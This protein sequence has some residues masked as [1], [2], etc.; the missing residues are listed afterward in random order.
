MSSMRYVRLLYAV[1]TTLPSNSA[2]QAACN[3]KKRV[4]YWTLKEKTFLSY[5]E[6]STLLT[7]FRHNI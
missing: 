3:D 5:S 7:N 6:V 4:K 1:I 2:L